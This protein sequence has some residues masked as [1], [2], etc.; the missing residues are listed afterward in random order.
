MEI[1]SSDRH[2]WAQNITLD[3]RNKQQEGYSLHG[4][5]G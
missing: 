2:W 3:F 1:D 5:F 4:D